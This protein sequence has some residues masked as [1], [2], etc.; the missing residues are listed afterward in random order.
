MEHSMIP[1]LTLQDLPFLGIWSSRNDG[2]HVYLSIGH[3]CVNATL[4]N[5]TKKLITFLLPPGGPL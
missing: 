2:F 5:I 1:F 3:T 4:K